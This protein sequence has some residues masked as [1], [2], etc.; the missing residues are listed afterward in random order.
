MKFFFFFFFRSAV[1]KHCLS[2]IARNG[3]GSFEYYDK[4][5]KSKWHPKATRQLKY[6]SQP[7]LNNVRLEWQE[8]DYDRRSILQAP[9]HIGCLFN[10]SHRVIYGLIPTG[11]EVFMAFLKAN[12]GNYEFGTMVSLAASCVTSGKLL[13]TVAARAVIRDWEDGLLAE[14]VAKQLVSKNSSTSDIVNLSKEYSVLTSMTSFIAVEERGEKRGAKK[15]PTID[16][17]LRDEDVDIL[18]YMQW[19]ELERQDVVEVLEERVS[20]MGDEPSANDITTFERDTERKRRRL[21]VKDSDS[22]E[23]GSDVESMAD[24]SCDDDDM[25]MGLFGT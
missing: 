12:S 7:G 6:C 20:L 18:P 24:G 25:G 1:N 5:F 22:S 21:I 13:H 8:F 11:L 14:D 10:E 3:G 9:R 15:G 2:L 17:L 23:D 4:S 16:E 19:M